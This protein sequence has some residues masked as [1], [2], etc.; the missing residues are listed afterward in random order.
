VGYLTIE[1]EVG[2]DP[3]GDIAAAMRFLRSKMA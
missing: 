1:R 2:D 3:A